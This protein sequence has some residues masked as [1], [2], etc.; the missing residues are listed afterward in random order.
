[1]A[2]FTVITALWALAAAI[3]TKKRRAAAS[4]SARA[5][6][7]GRSRNARA[8]ALPCLP[9]VEQLLARGGK[10][11]FTLRLLASKL[12]R[13]ADRFGLFPRFALGRLFVRAPLLHFAKYAFALHFL[14]QDAECLID[15]VVANEDLQWIS[16]FVGAAAAV[17]GIWQIPIGIGELSRA[18]RKRVALDR[19]L[20]VT[21]V[22]V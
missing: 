1:M 10:E 4:D 7:S 16:F 5:E 20:G 13:A 9:G 3:D 6:A 14:L 17:M 19:T 8:R 2:A 12:T 22:K 21:Q 11:P 15:I 18:E